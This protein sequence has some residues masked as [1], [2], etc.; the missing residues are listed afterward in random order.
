MAFE[1]S[2]YN[3]NI[4]FIGFKSKFRTKKVTIGIY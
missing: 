1:M 2:T 4:E 3:E